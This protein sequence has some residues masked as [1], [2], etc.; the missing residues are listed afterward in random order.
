VKGAVKRG[1]NKRKRGERSGRN[2]VGKEPSN[3]SWAYTGEGFISASKICPAA[4]VMVSSFQYI[5]KG[6]GK[7]LFFCLLFWPVQ[8]YFYALL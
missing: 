5:S 7:V 8:I 6:R 3:R 1:D 2:G 4:L